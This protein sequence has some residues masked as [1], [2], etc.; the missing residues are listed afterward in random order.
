MRTKFR[1]W[2]ATKGSLFALLIL[3]GSLPARAQATND[4][5]SALAS[6][7]GAFSPHTNYCSTTEVFIPVGAGNLGYCIEK[8]ERAAVPWVTAKQEC[9]KDGKR[10]PEPAEWQQACKTNPEGALVNMTNDWEFASNSPIGLQYTNGIA[11]LEVIEMGNGGCTYANLN[12]PGFLG[13][14]IS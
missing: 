14:P 6:A 5:W 11:D 2:L 1:K 8:T 13:G 10:L 9:A 4:M 7:T 3:A 12:R